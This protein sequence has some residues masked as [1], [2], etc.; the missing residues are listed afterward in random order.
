MN[1]SFVGFETPYS[2]VFVVFFKIIKNKFN[3][4]REVVFVF[5]IFVLPINYICNI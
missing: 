3:T 2:N 4:F 5:H 1:A